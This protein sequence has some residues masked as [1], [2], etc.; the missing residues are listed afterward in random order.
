M[1]GE[2]NIYEIKHRLNQKARERAQQLLEENAEEEYTWGM[3]FHDKGML[4][5]AFVCF[6]KAAKGKHLPAAYQLSLCYYLGEGTEPDIFKAK[7]WLEWVFAQDSPEAVEDL[8]EI[9]ADVEETGYLEAIQEILDN[10]A[11]QAT[12]GDVRMQY[13]LGMECHT[14]ED[15]ER[16]VYWLS[17]P[18]AQKDVRCLVLL[19]DIYKEHGNDHEAFTAYEK[20][21]G[22]GDA[23]AE[24]RLGSC[25]LLGKG[26]GQNI[27]EAI[28]WM[29]KAEAQGNYDGLTQLGRYF[30]D[31]ESYETAVYWFDR[32]IGH[33]GPES[34]AQYDRMLAEKAL[35]ES[36]E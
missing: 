1:A 10:Y 2:D 9:A 23:W 11:E 6:S 34:F 25:Y 15:D 24:I 8:A 17:L 27:S 19:G 32:V 29:E 33:E 14:D 22:K 12:A 35:K 20:A 21:A 18:E 26:V 7:R 16:A 3:E 31:H 13:T 4:K 5:D 36:G 30:Y 28:Y